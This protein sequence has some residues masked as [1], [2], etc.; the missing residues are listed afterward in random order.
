MLHVGSL[1]L[2]F[3][4]S[5]ALGIKI[6][7]LSPNLWVGTGMPAHGNGHLHCIQL[8]IYQGLKAAPAEPP[9]RASRSAKFLK[10]VLEK[11]RNFRQLPRLE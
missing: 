5:G 9:A 3:A 7:S 4:L 2:L 6:S 1:I 10:T 8:T 11:G